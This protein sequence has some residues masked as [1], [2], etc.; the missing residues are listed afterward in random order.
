VLYASR[1]QRAYDRERIDRASAEDL[2]RSM[3]SRTLERVRLGSSYLRDVDDPTA[4][5]RLGMLSEPR[6]DAPPTLAGC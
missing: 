1:T 4:L 5:H 6:S 2:D 3:L